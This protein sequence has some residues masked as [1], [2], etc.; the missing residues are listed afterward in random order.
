MFKIL[1]IDDDPIV[2]TVLKKTLQNQGYDI[3]VASNGEEGI[4]QAKL[5]HPALIIC[6]W[7]MSQLDGLEVVVEL[8]QIQSWQLLFLFY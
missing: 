5:L 7:M 2:L 6:D 4:K 8:E 1:V 3:T